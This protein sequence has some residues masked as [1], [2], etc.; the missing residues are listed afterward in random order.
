MKVQFFPDTHTL[1][2]SLADRPAANA[3]E[4]PGGVI[5]ERDAA[6]VVVGIVI[7]DTRAIPGFDPSV[8]V[9]VKQGA[10]S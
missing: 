3:E 7:D 1:A 6:D 4:I 5:I 10:L 2:I 9:G 8:I